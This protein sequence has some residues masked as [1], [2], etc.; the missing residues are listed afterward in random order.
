MPSSPVL[1]LICKSPVVFSIFESVPSWYIC[2][3]CESPS[4]NLPVSLGIR[5]LPVTSNWPVTFTPVELVSNRLV[6]SE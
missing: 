5:V 6:P 2:K 3:S 1:G 4:C